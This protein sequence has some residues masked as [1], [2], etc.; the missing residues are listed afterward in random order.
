MTEDRTYETTES[1]GIPVR[2]E[3]ATTTFR[4]TTPVVA[5]SSPDVYQQTQVIAPRDRVRW[6]PIVAGLL[7][8]IGTFLLLSTLALVIGVGAVPRGADAG[9][10]ASASGIVTALIGLLSFLIGGFVAGRTAA[11]EGRGSG[12][13]NGFLVWALGIVLILLIAALGL[14]GLF[15]A[16]GDLFSQY[17]AAG[18]PQPDVDSADVAQGIRDAALPAFL[19]LA[20]PALAATIG[21]FFGGRDELGADVRQV[22]GRAF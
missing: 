19:G 21:G 22:G 12:A 4:E 17:R 5:Q 1:G 15:G 18:S 9:D 10:T 2:R 6:G 13:L 11:V 3:T 20:L 16:A 8:A 7:T 14:G